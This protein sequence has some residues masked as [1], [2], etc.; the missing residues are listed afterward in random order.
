MS[1]FVC[2]D[3]RF[4]DEFWERADD[5]DV[6][7][8]PANWPEARRLPWKA[9]LQARAIENMAYVIGCN[10]V[11]S[12]N[13]LPYS[14]DSQIIDPLGE[15]LA[16]HPGPAVLSCSAL[17]RQYRERPRRRVPGLRAIL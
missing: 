14:G 15:I 6:Y 10:R 12:G 11:G 7:L 17:K 13:G 3:L 2:Y 16:S 8:V 1:L 9:L 4:A 5:T